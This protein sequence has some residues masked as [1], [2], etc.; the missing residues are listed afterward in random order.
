M[1]RT[2]RVTGAFTA[3]GFLLVRPHRNMVLC[4]KCDLSIEKVN[5]TTVLYKNY[6]E[7]QGY[8]LVIEFI[9]VVMVCTA[10]ASD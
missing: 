5:G 1:N 7:F 6:A 3:V 2:I 9:N 10:N 8:N 4:E